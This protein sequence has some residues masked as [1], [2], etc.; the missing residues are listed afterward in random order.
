MKAIN[1]SLLG[2]ASALVIL[3]G[4]ANN[5]LAEQR[6]GTLRAYLGGNPASASLHEESSITTVFPFMPVFNNLVVFNH[7]SKRASADDLTPELATEWRWSDDHTR[8]T[9]QLRQGVTWHD[10]KPFTS[11]DVKCTWDTVTGKRDAGWRKNPRRDWYTNLKEV[12]TNGD[13]EVSFQL[14]RPQPSFISFLAV[15]FSAVYPCHV[16]ARTMRQKPIGTGPF[17]VV[18]F[19]P[20]QRLELARNPDYWRPDRPFLDGITYQIISSRATRQ[21]A[22]VA[23]EFDLTSAGDISPPLMV[24]L[25]KQVPDA[26]CDTPFANV[27]GQILMN[28]KV[29]P[30]DNPQIR[31]A[32]ALSLDRDAFINILS[33]GRFAQGGALVPPPVGSWGVTPEDLAKAGVPGYAGTLE[34]RREEARQ[35]MRELGYSAEKPLRIKL[36]SRDFASYRDPAVILIDHMKTVFIEAELQLLETSQWYNTLPRD[37]WGI[38]QNLT[39]VAIDD[40]DVLLYESYMCGSPRNYSRYC[41]ED[42]QRKVEE[43]SAMLD[44]AARKRLVQEIDIQLQQELA[45]PMLFHM[46]SGTCRQA[47]V[48]GL[49]LAENNYYTH[50]RMENVWLA[51]R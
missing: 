27:G 17:R 19:E 31:R 42:L 1:R 38:A 7:Q 24:D 6:G 14:E 10:G 16:D 43:Q 13:F 35:I 40:P 3:T 32:V 37:T 26:Q 50:Y 36:I 48:R 33:Q 11:A 8:L 34:E 25:K 46:V 5:A 15:G 28:R 29:A 45:R 49:T 47:N 4:A 18:A 12:T 30:F 9:F 39:G 22:F 44:P 41:N 2:L 51:P 21:L 20:N 23:G